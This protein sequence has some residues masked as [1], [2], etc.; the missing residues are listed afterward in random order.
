MKQHQF[1]SLAKIRGWKYSLMGAYDDG[2]D[3]ETA[4]LELPEYN[5][6]AEYWVQELNAD[7]AF[8]E[9]GIWLYVATDQVRFVDLNSE[10][11]IPLEQV[12]ALPFSEVMRDVDLFVGVASVGNDPN[13]G[14]S[15]GL[16][17][18]RD[19]WNLYS[20]GELGEIAK[21]RREI[22]SKLLPRLKIRNIAKIQD[23]FLVVQGKRRTYKI[24][25]G[26]SN[27][28]MEPN[29]A[30]LCIV[31]DRNPGKKTESLFLPFEGDRGLS[32]VLSKAFLLAEDDKIKDETIVSQIEGS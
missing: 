14:D 19:Y 13:W 1:N 9:T 28:L 18:Y 12:P 26:S 11:A 22:L 2:R 31:P 21:N 3:I 20:F 16:P 17:A 29:D 32:I 4:Q 25:L 5:L 30:Y 6:R 27:I 8:N 23:R 15:G 10:E 7:D 24:H